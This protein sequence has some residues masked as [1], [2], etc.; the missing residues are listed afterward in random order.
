MWSP[1]NAP[2]PAAAMMPARLGS[3]LAGTSRNWELERAAGS[4]L[5]VADRLVRR[6]GVDG[7]PI[8]AWTIPEAWDAPHRLDVGVAF[9]GAD[10]RV[11]SVAESLTFWPFTHDELL[12][13]L[14]AAGLAV[15]ATT[16]ALNAERY[17]D[18]TRRSAAGGGA[19]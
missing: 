18:T 19:G 17:L 12:A 16:F 10:G 13:D 8:H 2:A 9:P 7:L 15:E 4:R 5:E 14:R 3:P 11:E 1:T 6:G